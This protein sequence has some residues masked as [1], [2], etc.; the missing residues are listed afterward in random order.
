MFQK[1][2]TVY[3]LSC[4]CGCSNNNGFGKLMKPVLRDSDSKFTI[5]AL[6]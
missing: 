3:V 2:F 4:S 5:Q 1:L 6:L